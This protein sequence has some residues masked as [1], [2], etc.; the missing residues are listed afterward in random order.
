[1]AG[2]RFTR[3]MIIGRIFEV[4]IGLIFWVSGLIKLRDPSLFLADME[5]FPF[6][7][8]PIAFATALFLPWL[9][10]ISAVGL[11][12]GRLVRGSLA[13][14]GLLTAAFIGFLAIARLLEIEASCGCFG[15]WLVFPSLETHI[16]FNALML[17]VIVVLHRK[18][19][20]RDQQCGSR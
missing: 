11:I 13:I 5:A 20:E 2:S 3:G 8:Y 17:G 16:A 12:S 7:P 10:L 1:M 4:L 18:R 9:E 6:L 19:Q 14:L 15:E